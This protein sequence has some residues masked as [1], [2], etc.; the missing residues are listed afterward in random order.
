MN[1]NQIQ[2]IKGTNGFVVY[3][4]FGSVMHADATKVVTYSNLTEQANGYKA[5]Q[6]A[7]NNYK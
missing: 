2:V 4:P 1:A 6:K 7:L 5:M 3:G